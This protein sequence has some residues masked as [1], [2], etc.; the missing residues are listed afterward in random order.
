MRSPWPPRPSVSSLTSTGRL[1]SALGNRRGQRDRSLLLEV[2]AEVADGCESPAER[3]YVRDVERAHGLPHGRSQ[4][5]F[6]R[7]GRRDREYEWG[8]VVEVDGRL[9]HASWTDVQ[10]DGRRDR[11][12]LVAG[13]VTLRCYWT[14]LVPSPCGLAGEVAQVLRARGWAGRPRRCGPGCSIDD[15]AQVVEPRTPVRGCDLPR[16]GGGGPPGTGVTAYV[17]TCQRGTLGV[18]QRLTNAIPCGGSS[19]RPS[20]SGT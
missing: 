15:S 11:S 10:R 4:S 13:R 3:R 20:R 18:Y 5:P 9:G 8:V 2:F 16:R 7:V 14:D 1:R 12:A 19:F 17:M 6:G